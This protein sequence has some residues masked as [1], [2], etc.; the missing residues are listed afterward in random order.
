MSELLPDSKT[1]KDKREKEDWDHDPRVRI[2]RVT[3]WPSS[4]QGRVWVN[5]FVIYVPVAML[6]QKCPGKL[7]DFVGLESQIDGETSDKKR[8][9]T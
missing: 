4:A 9:L 7:R 3:I 1:A 6:Q 8:K 2:E 5:G